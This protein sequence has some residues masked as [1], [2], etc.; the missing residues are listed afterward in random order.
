MK[1][2]IFIIAL[3]ALSAAADYT[4]SVNVIEEVEVPAVA[5]LVENWISLRSSMR[6]ARSLTHKL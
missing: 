2:F 3:L 1:R 6:M 4:I 5:P